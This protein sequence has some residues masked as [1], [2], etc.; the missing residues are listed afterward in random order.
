[1]ASNY[2]YLGPD[3]NLGE[4]MIGQQPAPSTTLPVQKSSS[5][6]CLFIVL[7]SVAVLLGALA[8]F[9]LVLKDSNQVTA[10][11]KFGASEAFSSLSH[12]SKYEEA[13]GKY[14]LSS[15]NKYLAYTTKDKDVRVWDIQTNSLL[16][17]FKSQNN[18]R[19]DV[20]VSLTFMSENKTILMCTHRGYLQ[21]WDLRSK[22]EVFKNK[23]PYEIRSLEVTKDYKKAVLS[24]NNSI[25]VWNFDT[26]KVEREIQAPSQIVS[27]AAFSVDNQFVA[28]ID[29]EGKVYVWNFETDAKVA[30]LDYGNLADRVQFTH[31]SKY[32]LATGIGNHI[33]VWNISTL[34]QVADIVHED[35]I[36]SIVVSSDSKYI[37]SASSDKAVKISEIETGALAGY[38]LHSKKV[39]AA[40]ISQG[41]RYLITADNTEH[42][43]V[44]NLET[45]AQVSDTDID[46]ELVSLK[47]SSDQGYLVG[48][49]DDG[50]L[51]LWKIV[52]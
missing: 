43:K 47:L 20:V 10:Q 23:F 17:E 8:F 19:D 9:F 7:F 3:N 36:H 25:R 4:P 29:I 41:N 15:D 42:L 35:D 27:S 21:I 30:Q 2:P 50:E 39:K 11:I 49:D 37:V 13:K 18:A 38:F 44:V 52:F 31:D 14:A 24:V 51:N 16:A 40:A 6:T 12:I 5:K 48:V 34:N 46:E 1:M 28:A 33:K 32:V 26:Q 45:K 22:A